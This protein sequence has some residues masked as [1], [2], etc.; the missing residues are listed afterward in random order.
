L[1]EPAS[2]R[3]LP[4][5]AL[6]VWLL[7][8][9]PAPA[10]FDEAEYE[11]AARTI[12]C[13]CG[14]HPQSVHDCACGRAA[15][16]RREI[17]AMIEQGRSGEEVIGLYVQQHGEKIRIAPT[18]RGFNLVAWLGPLAGLV[19]ATAC[20]VLLERRWSRRPPVAPAPPATLP[21]SAT[22]DDPYQARLRQE[23]E[24]W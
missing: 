11:K 20:L 4:A 8:G 21:V 2:R 10:A 5:L 7:C 24:Q 14:C 6:G 16:M 9:L 23:L 17:A 13:D 3:L 19:L 15:E 12:L 1:P 18:T 22:A